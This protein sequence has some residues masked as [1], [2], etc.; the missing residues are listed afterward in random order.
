MVNRLGLKIRFD[1][2]QTG[3]IARQETGM[4]NLLKLDLP[5]R[6]V[7]SPNRTVCIL[8]YIER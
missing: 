5:R 8:I 1:A 2:L 3:R 6:P 4:F 7:L